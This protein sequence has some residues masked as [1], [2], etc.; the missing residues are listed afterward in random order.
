[1]NEEC[2]NLPYTMHVKNIEEIKTIQYITDVNKHMREDGW[3][4][5]A[6]RQH[7]DSSGNAYPIYILGIPRPKYCPVCKGKEVWNHTKGEWTCPRAGTDACRW[8]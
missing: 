1:M 3:A 2:Y 6:I 8:R 4:L 5:L 7:A